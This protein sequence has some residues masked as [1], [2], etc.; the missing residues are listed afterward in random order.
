MVLNTFLMKVLVLILSFAFIVTPVASAQIKTSTVGKFTILKENNNVPFDGT[1]F[2]PLAT[3]HILLD[4]QYRQSLFDIELKF[5]TQM[6]KSDYE[7]KLQNKDIE[8]KRLSEEALEIEQT[9][10]KENEQLKEK[11]LSPVSVDFI[12]I[13]EYMLI[14]VAIGSVGTAIIGCV[15]ACDKIF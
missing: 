6:I 12:N 2:D 14:G 3:A 8:F 1:L 4:K 15:A 10:R 13:F 7:Y 9:L 11:A 5:S